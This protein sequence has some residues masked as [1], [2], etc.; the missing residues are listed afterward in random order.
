M[1]GKRPNWSDEKILQVAKSVTERYKR[2]EIKNR[3]SI[4]IEFHKATGYSQRFS[5]IMKYARD[6]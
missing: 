1:P 4:E 3:W 2:G 5:T 6:I